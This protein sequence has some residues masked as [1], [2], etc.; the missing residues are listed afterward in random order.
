M[1]S[2]LIET[3]QNS[4]SSNLGTTLSGLNIGLVNLGKNVGLAILVGVNAGG[5]LLGVTV[6]SLWL[7]QPTS[8]IKIIAVQT[9]LVN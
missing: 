7:V 5:E 2:P 4:S 1:M 6:S 3:P 8:N 9:P